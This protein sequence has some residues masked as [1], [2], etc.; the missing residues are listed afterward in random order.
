MGSP[1]EPVSALL[2][3]S[4]EGFERSIDRSH[5]GE[6]PSHALGHSLECLLRAYACFTSIETANAIA[7]AT[8]RFLQSLVRAAVGLEVV[9]AQAAIMAIT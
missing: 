2:Q 6:D 1:H 8:A 4:T 9:S 5:G 3:R 7:A